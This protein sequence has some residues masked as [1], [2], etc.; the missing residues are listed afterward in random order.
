MNSGAVTP[1]L[2]ASASGFTPIIV[3]W[4]S[5]ASGALPAA[6]YPGAGWGYTSPIITGVALAST[7]DYTI[8][9]KEPFA[10]L[11]MGA[12]VTIVQASDAKT[13][14]CTGRV[15]EDHST[16]ATPEVKIRI[17]DAAGDA[18]AP[19]TGDVV[20]IQLTCQGFNQFA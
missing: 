5:R 16:N 10:G 9:F 12:I 1:I 11:L 6:A 7:A 8:S 4:T 17:V 18:T 2:G 13:G 3:S 14:A 15:I 20:T 19:T